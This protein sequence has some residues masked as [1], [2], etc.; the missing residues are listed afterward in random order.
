MREDGTRLGVVLLFLKNHRLRQSSNPGLATPPLAKP[1]RQPRAILRHM[2]I[3]LKD[4]YTF[5]ADTC[6]PISAQAFQL[7]RGATGAHFLGNRYE[8]VRVRFIVIP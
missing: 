6:S 5:P 7:Q 3:G 4:D 1:R 2:R 8:V